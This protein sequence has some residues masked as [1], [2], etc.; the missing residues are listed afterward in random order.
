[1][2]CFRY[3]AVLGHS[4]FPPFVF[5]ILFLYVIYYLI[6]QQVFVRQQRHG[7]FLCFFEIPVCPDKRSVCDAAALLESRCGHSLLFFRPLE[8]NKMDEKEKGRGVRGDDNTIRSKWTETRPRSLLNVSPAKL[9]LN[10]PPP[11]SEA[12]PL[13]SCWPLPCCAPGADTSSRR[14][15]VMEREWR[16]G[17][18]PHLYP[19]PPSPP[20]PP[21]C[22][23]LDVPFV[24]CLMTAVMEPSCSVI[25]PAGSQ[26]P[27]PSLALH[28]PRA[29][30]LGGGWV[31]WGAL[32]VSRGEPHNP[33]LS[34]QMRGRGE[35]E[36]KSHLGDPRFVILFYFFA[37]KN[38][39]VRVLC[40]CW[41]ALAE[42]ELP[43]QKKYHF[44][45]LRNCLEG[46]LETCAAGCVS[47][48]LPEH[49]PSFCRSAY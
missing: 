21:L 49:I 6:I 47:C 32:K 33:T 31:G 48:C 1:M 45:L 17:P 30:R 35:R 38:M 13:H 27:R 16:G 26:A 34:P 12:A 18:T 10:L 24:W 8:I 46:S 41:A 36:E 22:P 37:E 20:L 3:W 23:A 11:P 19:S 4:L 28:R 42:S 25:T 40:I 43:H 14:D 39:H 44:H 9:H 5:L 15:P 7:T 29:L 2:D